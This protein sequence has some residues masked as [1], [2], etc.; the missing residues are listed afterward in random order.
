MP[1][2]GPWEEAYA[3]AVALVSQMT[4]EEK[5]N[6]T[7]GYTPDSGCSGVTGSVPRLNW[8]GISLSDAG[9]RKSV[10]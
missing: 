8:P 1:G 9:D 3:K 10:V 4:L 2:T 7:V 5:S 6:V